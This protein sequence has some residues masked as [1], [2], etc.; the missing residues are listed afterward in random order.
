MASTTQC[1]I[2]NTSVLNHFSSR[3]P[4]IA[5]DSCSLKTVDASGFKIEFENEDESGGFVSVHYNSHLNR[6]HT[7]REH[8]CFINNVPCYANEHRFGG[9]V[10]QPLNK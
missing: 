1:F 2:C 9:I 6:T 5:C 10:I 7:G 3:Y 4:L 8:S